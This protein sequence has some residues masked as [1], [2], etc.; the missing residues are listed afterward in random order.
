MM[1]LILAQICLTVGTPD[2]VVTLCYVVFGLKMIVSI[3]QSLIKTIKEKKW[4]EE[5]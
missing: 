4:K 2:W 3:A 5:K 1:Y